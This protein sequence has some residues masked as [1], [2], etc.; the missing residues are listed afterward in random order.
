MFACAQLK[1]SSN[2][3]SSQQMRKLQ[4][5]NVVGLRVVNWKEKIAKY[6][7][8]QRIMYSP[9]ETR[10]RGPFASSSG[11]LRLMILNTVINMAS[12]LPR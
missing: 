7:G 11:V 6:M 8:N 3:V 10:K 2:S 9:N 12:F 5:K 4:S 1:Q